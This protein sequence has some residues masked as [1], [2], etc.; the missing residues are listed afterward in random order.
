MT[1]RILSLSCVSLACSLFFGCSQETCYICEPNQDLACVSIMDREGSVTTINAEERLKG[2]VSVNFMTPQPYE[3]VLRVYKKDCEGNSYAYVTSYHPNGQLKQYLEIR[4]AGAYG[5]YKEWHENSTLKFECTL[6]GGEP[7]ITSDAQKSW[8]FDGVC[9]AWDD[10]SNLIATYNYC[11]GSLEGES[12]QYYPGDIVR[13]RTPYTRNE[14]NGTVEM[15]FPDGSSM[16]KAK[17]NNGELHGEAIRYWKSG[18]VAAE[19]T[20][21]YSRIL[22]GTYYNPDGTEVAAI[23]DGYGFRPT[24]KQECLSELCEFQEGIPG[25][26]IKVLHEKGY[27][28]SSHHIKDGV[29]DGIE[30]FYYAPPLGTKVFGPETQKSQLMITWRDGRIHG[31]TK[32]WYPDGNI[33]SQREMADNQRNGLLTAWYRDGSFMLVEEYENNRLV[34][35]E[36]FKRG[37]RRPETK[38]TDGE[39]IATLYDADGHFLRRLSYF[40]GSPLD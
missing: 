14:I 38:V 32:S 10:C 3:K 19:E 11:K 1:W 28:I 8:Q 18:I 13:A 31:V 12:I 16:A 2:Y 40:H 29:K 37:E 25:G 27:L 5:A 15:F 33:E 6:V 26:E 4:N 7:D 30:T 21:E 9:K 36:Y 34:K 23:V 22:A 35:G 17:W 24:Y 39:G 20:F